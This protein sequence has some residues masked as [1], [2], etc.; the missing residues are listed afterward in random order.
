[1]IT[2]EILKNA[3]E[4]NPE[5]GIFI[6]KPIEALTKSNKMWN[7]QYAGKVTGSIRKDG[8]FRI[9]IN[10]KRYL[11]HR[12]AWL[13]VYGAMPVKELDHKDG[14]RSNNKISNLRESTSS[15]NG[16]NVTKRKTNTSGYKGVV[17][18]PVTR[19]WGASIWY[20][21]KK[22]S[23]GYFYKIEDA[24]KAYNDASVK[25]AGEF[26]RTVS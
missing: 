3:V 23:L 6:K 5:T 20:E 14:D 12:L 8:Y 16:H 21:N 18:Y 24:A 4:Y 11:A 19:K 22:Y 10:G 7:G 13:Y 9:C 25:L 17:W 1:M 15:Q 26:A 2:Q